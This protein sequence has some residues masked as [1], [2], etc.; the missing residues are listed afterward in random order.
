MSWGVPRPDDTLEPPGGFAPEPVR[1]LSGREAAENGLLLEVNRRLLHPRGLA[2][3]AT[4]TK[5]PDD[6]A[7]TRAFFLSDRGLEQLR[8]LARLARENGLQPVE[9][10]DDL[11]EELAKADSAP[12]GVFHIQVTDDPEGFEYAAN[13]PGSDERFEKSGRFEALLRPG[14]REALGYVVQPLGKP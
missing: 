8:E 2:L 9:W 6:E 4:V 7:S 10:C 14:R 3:A 11:D 13:D 5:D 12:L 1:Y